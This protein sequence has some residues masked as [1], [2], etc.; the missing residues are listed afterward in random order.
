[1][2]EPFPNKPTFT[3]FNE[4]RRIEAEVFDL[5]VEGVLP[6]E[7][8]GAFYRCGP[9]PRFA[10]R[11]G[12][13]INI[14]GDGMVSVFRFAGGHVDFQ[15]RYVRTE[16]Y[17]LETAARKALF[18]MYRNPYT[19]DPSV[20]GKDRTT[21][22]TNIVQHAGRLFALKEDGLPHEM[23]PLTLETRGRYDYDGKLRSQT[24][25]AHPK[26]DPETGEMVSFGYEARGLATRDMALQVI[27]SSG[28]LRR[29]E[30]F[31]AP[32]ASFQHDFAVSARH[33]VFALMPTVADDA[34][35][36]AGGTHWAFEGDR[37]AAIGIVRRDA[38]ISEIR[39]FSAP[40]QGI[41]HILNAFSEG[42]KVYVDVFV[43]ERNQ[44]PFVP[45]ADGSAFDRVR[46]VP[47]LTR[48]TFDL[49]DPSPRF[50]AET[51]FPDFMEM[52]RTDDRYQMHP[53]RFGYTVL[54]DRTK[55]PVIAGTIGL[56]WNTLARLDLATRTM[57]RYYV[58]DNRTCQEPQFIPRSPGGPEGDGY[59][60]S[61]ITS[62]DGEIRNELIVMDAQRI[63][64][65]PIATVKLPFRLRGAIHGNWVPAK[66]L[67]SKNPAAHEQAHVVR[68]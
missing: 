50:H 8:D 17:L 41:G 34:R 36:R 64:E 4:P 32:Y 3:G 11:S 63:H 22:N 33:I 6:Q 43:S 57:D 19:D 12:D 68:R 58:G 5:D 40:P 10:P 54:L 37:N 7:L 30:F 62:Y 51:L 1:M 14:N 24:F 65:G 44:F 61:M 46:S 29:E 66:T 25:T 23:D 39:W 49:S 52:P 48:W 16:K 53:Y 20:A 35:M 2:R 59:L 13:D 15:C 18:G 27:D 45:N 67:S 42:D 47:R 56:G 9:D 21:A 31:T 26:I 28:A 38:S 55:P 60:L